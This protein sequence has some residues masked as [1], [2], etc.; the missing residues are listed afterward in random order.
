MNKETNQEQSHLEWDL[1][2]FLPC[3]PRSTA[4]HISTSECERLSFVHKRKRA[5]WIKVELGATDR[6]RPS[7]SRA[8][9]WV[10]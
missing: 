6:A 9:F 8:H 3:G 5:Y 4:Q 2:S 7:S 10:H 1:L